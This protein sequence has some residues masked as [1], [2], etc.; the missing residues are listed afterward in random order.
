M[1]NG[2]LRVRD[3]C[4]DSLRYF[5]TNGFLPNYEES[6]RYVKQLPRAHPV[7]RP[8]LR[9][10]AHYC[11]A[12]GALYESSY[13]WDLAYRYV[14][15][16]TASSVAR[17]E[18]ETRIPRW[19]GSFGEKKSTDLLNLFMSA[20]VRCGFDMTDKNELTKTARF[21]MKE[22]SKVLKLPEPYG[23]HLH[24]RQGK[25]SWEEPVD[26]RVVV[27]CRTASVMEPPGGKIAFQTY[28]DLEL[29]TFP[30][31]LLPLLARNLARLLGGALPG[32]VKSLSEIDR[33]ILRIATD[34]KRKALVGTK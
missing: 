14:R 8:E 22:S 2:T 29:S 25:P 27:D 7:F 4:R 5:L 18:F 30:P 6:G 24:L 10:A 31:T 26:L 33:E 15:S 9:L 20:M 19:C 21:E 12:E 34:T 17:G 13:D 3:L 1:S 23:K 32:S 11:L 28:L 16:F